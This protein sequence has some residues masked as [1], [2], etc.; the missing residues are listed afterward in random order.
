MSII[1]CYWKKT[2]DLLGLHPTSC[3]PH[4]LK[5]L[6]LRMDEFATEY[7][8]GGRKDTTKSK[9]SDGLVVIETDV[10][11]A[12]PTSLSG[13]L[14]ASTG[15][16]VSVPPV[17]DLPVTNKVRKIKSCKIYHIG[18]DC[19][20]IQKSSIVGPPYL[21][22]SNS[23]PSPTSIFELFR[24]N[25]PTFE[26]E[27]ESEEYS[28][29]NKWPWPNQSFLG[30]NPAK[31][32]I[33]GRRSNGKTFRTTYCAQMVA[34]YIDKSNFKPCEHCR[35]GKCNH[36]DPRNDFKG[37]GKKKGFCLAYLDGCQCKRK[38]CKFSHIQIVTLPGVVSKSQ[39]KRMMSAPRTNTQ[40]CDKKSCSL[41][42]K[43]YN[44]S[45][46]YARSAKGVRSILPVEMLERIMED[47]HNWKK[48]FLGTDLLHTR[49]DE[50]T[51]LK[52]VYTAI[53][54]CMQRE[55]IRTFISRYEKERHCFYEPVEVCPENF[56][57][58]ALQWKKY[59]DRKNLLFTGFDKEFPDG[60]SEH[61]LPSFALYPKEGEDCLRQKIVEYMLVRAFPCEKENCLNA[62]NCYKGG[63]FSYDCDYHSLY[64]RF[65]DSLTDCFEYLKDNVRQKNI[66]SFDWI[67]GNISQEEI[68]F[69]EDEV[70][71]RVVFL[72]KWFCSLKEKRILLK[73]K[74]KQDPNNPLTT[75]Q[76]SQSRSDIER[77]VDEL[78]KCWVPN[79]LTNLTPL[80]IERSPPEDFVE[81]DSEFPTIGDDI[82]ARKRINQMRRQRY[83]KVNPWDNVSESVRSPIVREPEESKLPKKPQLVEVKRP[84][85]DSCCLEE[86]TED[87]KE[88]NV[89]AD[90]YQIVRKRRSFSNRGNVLFAT[91]LS[92]L[93]FKR[94]FN[95]EKLR[96]L[97][98]KWAPLNRK[99]TLVRIPSEKSLK[100]MRK[101]WKYLTRK[102]DVKTSKVKKL[103]SKLTSKSKYRNGKLIDEANRF[104]KDRK[105]SFL[106]GVLDLKCRV[107]LI[108]GFH[109]WVEKTCVYEKRVL[110]KEVGNSNSCDR[111]EDSFFRMPRELTA[112]DYW[113]KK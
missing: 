24:S 83:E 9:Q 44:K 8:N 108:S 89:T 51:F 18:N 81:S 69:N 13:D 87:T 91:E 63:H 46:K 92:Y 66:Y 1:W 93:D 75:R 61:N 58:L 86:D 23:C 67:S 52:E 88:P 82:L 99:G 39:M 59:R 32:L 73:E 15:S 80:M 20:D 78:K 62:Q 45:C 43:K 49:Q 65:A 72:F 21:V 5:R 68:R 109:K 42:K 105:I 70:K 40:I 77:V 50:G 29:E 101:L 41:C 28:P 12:V 16:V 47:N 11:D 6:T 26:P 56:V 19:M 64:E 112:R 25:S 100:K 106:Q 36:R 107:G 31:V 103:L 17:G 48:Y 54:K 96:L 3:C 37:K 113:V 2:S 55:A 4:L 102:K 84:M 60:Y 104:I 71:K 10:G 38:S 30:I 111:D 53:A 14:E 7:K 34:H 94:V 76:L 57:Q 85:C 22:R 35:R 27:S 98:G 95:P 74:N 110:E 79:Y 97:D 33:D 90:G